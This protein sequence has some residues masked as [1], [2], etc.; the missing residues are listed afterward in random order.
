MSRCAI[1]S[2]LS[3]YRFEENGGKQINV[4]AVDE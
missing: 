1:K 3:A 4:K 2:I